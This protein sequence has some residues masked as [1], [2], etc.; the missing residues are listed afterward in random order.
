[1]NLVIAVVLFLSGMLAT[2]ILVDIDDG[3]KRTGF[4]ARCVLVAFN[5]AL[6]AYALRG[7]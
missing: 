6:T 5:I 3:V 2:T 4:Y 7:A 1:M